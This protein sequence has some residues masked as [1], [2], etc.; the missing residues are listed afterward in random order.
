M[1]SLLVAAALITTWTIVP[2]SAAVVLADDIG[3]KM[4][5]YTSKFQQ[6]RRSGEAV[7]IDGKCFSACTMVLGILPSNRIC[8]TQNAVLGF[9]AAW[10][11]DTAGKRVPSPV[12]TRDL[13]KTYPSSVR[14]WISRNG[15]LRPQMTYL[16]GSA[17][18]A[19]VRPCA[20]GGRDR[21]VEIGHARSGRSKNDRLRA[22]GE[23]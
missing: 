13:M 3:G 10:M 2:A 14:A 21:L 20:S 11:Y 1:R 4:E 5:D 12:G 19:I 9:H 7:V 16:Q 8:A 18:A 23:F 6:L 15:G 22:A 17:L